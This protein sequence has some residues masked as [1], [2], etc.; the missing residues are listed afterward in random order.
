MRS[1]LSPLVD[2]HGRPMA[3]SWTFYESADRYSNNDDRSGWLNNGARDTDDLLPTADWRTLMEESRK[4]FANAP[5]LRGAVIEQ[6]RYAFPLEPHY[7]GTD[8][9]WGKL[10]KEWLYHWK[11]TAD[12]R[13]FPYD[14]HRAARVRLISRLV[15][16][17][18]TR[19]F[20]KENGAPRLQFVRGHR[21]G[22]GSQKLDKDSRLESGPWKGY[23][24]KNGIVVNNYD[25]GLAICIVNP[26]AKSPSDDQ[27]VPE[28]PQQLREMNGLP[29]FVQTY[30]PDLSD[31]CRGISEISVSIASLK[32]H[33]RWRANEERA[34]EIQSAYAITEKND[35]GEN[36]GAVRNTDGTK[37][38]SARG[39]GLSV[40]TMEK[41]MIKFLRANS[42][43]ELEMLRPDRPG[44]GVLAFDDR[45]IEEIIYG[46]GWEPNFALLIK[47]PGGAW[48]RTILRKVNGTL[49]E[50]QQL[51][52]MSQLREDT[53]ALSV[54]INTGELDAPKDGDFVSWDYQGPPK[55]T[56][57]SGNEARAQME[58]YKL[59]L[60]TRRRIFAAEGLWQEEEDK[61]RLEETRSRLVDAKALLAEFPELKDINTAFALLEQRFANQQTTAPAE[62]LEAPGGDDDSAP[63]EDA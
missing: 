52:A 28:S 38:T 63:K 32:S 35:S 9:E 46:M 48:A 23:R 4:L 22:N 24:L 45:T 50:H 14:C 11:K 30:N 40:Q 17:D 39:S 53:W 25:R 60:I 61:S 13:G 55:I 26:N 49:G 1:A 57:D 37:V 2:P 15:D 31:Q 59:G 33:K 5:L 51:E 42:G 43:H 44:P 19:I 10:A 41:G 3:A 34:Q 47:Q 7:V 27:F 58:G 20:V 36:E 8:R 12:V 18:A 62:D 29:P 16:G 54:A 56:A 6:A 21:I